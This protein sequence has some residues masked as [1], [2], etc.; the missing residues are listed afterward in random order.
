MGAM[1]SQITS[2]AIVNSI[3]YS[4]A[5][6]SKQQSSVSLL[7]LRGIHQWPVISPTKGPVTRKI[8]SFDG[9]IMHYIHVHRVRVSCVLL[10]FGIEPTVLQMVLRVTSPVVAQLYDCNLRLIYSQNQLIIVSMTGPVLV[11]SPWQ[12]WNTSDMDTNRNDS[13][14]PQNKTL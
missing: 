6:Q 4:S 13:K 8:F 7:F 14:P 10:C 12:I 3:V 5:D 1:T 2:L 11:D 9:V